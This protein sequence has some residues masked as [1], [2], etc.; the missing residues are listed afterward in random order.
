MWLLQVFTQLV[1]IAALN[2]LVDNAAARLFEQEL[3]VDCDLENRL[4]HVELT[5]RLQMAP[6]T[7]AL[8][9]LRSL[10]QGRL[11]YTFATLALAPILREVLPDVFWHSVPRS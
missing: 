9:F 4:Q 7:I 5:L 11:K 10:K 1:P 6:P 2:E 3:P 8:G